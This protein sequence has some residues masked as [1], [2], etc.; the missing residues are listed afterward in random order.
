MDNR[1][2][3]AYS[4]TLSSVTDSIGIHSREV[5]CIMDVAWKKTFSR[6]SCRWIFYVAG[7]RAA[8]HPWSRPLWRLSLG[9]YLMAVCHCHSASPTAA[10][11]SFRASKYSSRLQYQTIREKTKLRIRGK[12]LAVCMMRRMISQPFK[13][14]LNH[15]LPF[16]SSAAKL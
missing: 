5:K 15:S 13:E 12:L 16:S 9:C 3:R 6:E 1:I 2:L 7:Y 8:S 14:Y 11:S 4:P 10:H